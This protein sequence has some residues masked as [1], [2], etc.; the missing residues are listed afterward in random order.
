MICVSFLRP[1]HEYCDIFFLSCLKVITKPRKKKVREGEEE[2]AD[3]CPTPSGR[4]RSR[5]GAATP[6][7][8]RPKIRRGDPGYDPYDFTSS[9]ED[10]ATPTNSRRPAG[11]SPDHEGEESMDT[12]ST[13]A[14]ASVAMDA[15]RLVGVMYVVDIKFPY[16]MS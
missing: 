4:K 5:R 12:E 1:F 11:G 7:Q 13:S 15:E 14:T 16:S 6:R 3:E 2:V 8:K 9:E 10:V